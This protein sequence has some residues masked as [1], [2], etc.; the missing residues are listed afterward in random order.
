MN[1]VFIGFDSNRVNL[2]KIL[3]FIAGDFHCFLDIYGEYL[4]SVDCE[5]GKMVHLIVLFYNMFDELGVISCLDDS[6]A[7]YEE[8]F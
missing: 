6:V 5:I 3:Y 7:S 1:M 2:I 8:L 4:S